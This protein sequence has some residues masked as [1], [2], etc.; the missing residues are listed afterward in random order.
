LST[1]ANDKARNR[2]Y[3]S[4]LS[5]PRNDAKDPLLGLIPTFNWSYIPYNHLLRDPLLSPYFAPRASL[6][7]NI[8]VIATELD[9]LA[10]ESWRF[11]T[12]LAAEGSA[13]PDKY[14]IPDAD[15]KELKQYLCGSQNVRSKQGKIEVLD[16][17]GEQERKYGFEVRWAGGGVKW[18]L[19][20]DTLH[21]FD[22]VHIRKLMGGEETV[23]DAEGKTREVMG[24]VGTWLRRVWGLEGVV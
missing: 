2:P 12:R 14:T 24:V 1:A 10:H 7:P 18:L 16:R 17:K 5:P 11:A 22:N 13:D 21:A 9:L 6:P 19:V 3:K 20:P 4:T 8:F 15:S 23:S